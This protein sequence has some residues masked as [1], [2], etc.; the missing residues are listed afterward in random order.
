M[1]FAKAAVVSVLLLGSCAR[2]ESPE[3]PDQSGRPT[4]AH[5]DHSPH[6]GGV[7]MM[8]GDLHY[9]VVLDPAGHHRLFFSDAMR[10]DLPASTASS[11]SITIF[12]KDRP[13]EPIALQID[14]AGESWAGMGEAVSEPATTT[15]RIAYTIRGEQPYWI[16]VPFEPAVADPNAPDPHKR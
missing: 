4:M 5:G 8:K 11:A 3:P 2:N 6:H 14:D 7:V 15:A 13:P 1:G 12:R 16:D 9:E 10:A